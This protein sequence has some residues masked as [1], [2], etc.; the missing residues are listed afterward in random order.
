ME[1]HHAINVPLSVNVQSSPNESSLFMPTVTA[2]V[3]LD[4]DA[5]VYIGKSAAGSPK[6]AAF[7]GVGRSHDAQRSAV[8]PVPFSL[9]G[10][11][12]A[13]VISRG[14]SNAVSA[15]SR[16]H[17][18]SPVSMRHA[19]NRSKLV[20]TSLAVR[21]GDSVVTRATSPGAGG[22]SPEP[23]PGLEPQ[24][25]TPVSPANVGAALTPP[26][27]SFGITSGLDTASFAMGGDGSRS[28][29]DPD[30]P[31]TA[32][33][34]VI[35]QRG[36]SVNR[37]QRAGS[38]H[39]DA[40]STGG[41]SGG[42][43][44]SGGLDTMLGKT[45]AHQRLCN[46][47]SATALR[48]GVVQVAAHTP[49]VGSSHGA[50]ST[51]AAIRT[52]KLP[53]AI[54]EALQVAVVREFV[55]LITANSNHREFAAQLASETHL[56][57]PSR[58]PSS[59]STGLGGRY[60][61][62]STLQE[63]ELGQH[64]GQHS[65]YP[66]DNFAPNG[67]MLSDTLAPVGSAP[68]AAES[69]SPLAN[70]PTL[71]MSGSDNGGVE[72]GARPP[73]GGAA[74]FRSL[75]AWSVS[76]A[77]FVVDQQQTRGNAKH[78]RTESTTSLVAT[79]A[80]VRSTAAAGSTQTPCIVVVQPFVAGG[81]IL[82]RFHSWCRGA[83][84]VD[85]EIVIRS[86]VRC[87]LEQLALIHACGEV[88]GSVKATN[89]FSW[90]D[91]AEAH[92]AASSPQQDEQNG[93]T[94]ATTRAPSTVGIKA[95]ARRRS[96]RL[97]YAAGTTGG[98]PL[99]WCT[100]VVLVDGLYHVLDDA[101]RRVLGSATPPH[102][103]HECW[104]AIDDY[105]YVLPPECLQKSTADVE[106]GEEASEDP[107][108][109]RSTAA[110]PRATSTA[111]VAPFSMSEVAPNVLHHR[112][113]QAADLWNIGLMA[114][115]VADGGFPS[116][117]RRQAKPVPSL[118]S[119]SGWSNK[120]ASFVQV[121]VSLHPEQRTSAKGLLHDPWFQSIIVDPAVHG[122]GGGGGLPS[123]SPTHFRQNVAVLPR[124]EGEEELLKASLL[125]HLHFRGA[126]TAATPAGHLGPMATPGGLAGASSKQQFAMAAH[127]HGAAASRPLR[128]LFDVC[129]DGTRVFLPQRNYLQTVA[130]L[131]FCC[132]QQVL[133]TKR[134][135]ESTSSRRLG[136]IGLPSMAQNLGT[137]L[138]PSSISMPSQLL[139]SVVTREDGDF[140]LPSNTEDAG[141]SLLLIDN[142]EDAADP[143][144]SIT[145]LSQQQ[146]C[147]GGLLSGRDRLDATYATQE[148]HSARTVNTSDA[149]EEEGLVGVA[150]P[151]YRPGDKLPTIPP[152]SSKP[153][154]LAAFLATMESCRRDS[155]LDC[156]YIVV[157]SSSTVAPA[158]S[159]T[160]LTIDGRELTVAQRREVDLVDH[161]YAGLVQAFLQLYDASPICGDHWLLSILRLMRKHPSTSDLIEPVVRCWERQPKHAPVAAASSPS[162]AQHHP[163]SQASKKTGTWAAGESEGASP[164][165]PLDGS[166]TDFNNYLFSKWITLG[167]M[168]VQER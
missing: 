160:V 110:T 102:T 63:S 144:D 3:A 35:L 30:S 108:K 129:E 91:V 43:V 25:P 42:P 73:E 151:A 118:S 100:D 157:T 52:F 125:Q 148:M 141:G 22:S 89:L 137:S 90:R 38:R 20:L 56:A 83:S 166:P 121:C 116:W 87:A 161:R 61:L 81:N 122:G 12:A 75:P 150:V 128:H 159:E 114:I 99:E 68:L 109:G 88:H 152:L 164:P 50:V 33:G 140:P 67:S 104:A 40:Y 13:L 80:A 48:I 158:C 60:R 53:S 107:S 92:D 120:F 156:G 46:V 84:R 130:E 106:G 124:N 5:P 74:V 9:D 45:S 96:S 29:A 7:R 155:L 76:A 111:P 143:R 4:M 6:G 23:T 136:T 154:F 147:S 131:E 115:H 16:V 153:P 19:P 127:H 72:P 15:A 51:N 66:S 71:V 135:V 70:Q 86:I 62:S 168:T 163:A 94:A 82:D 17:P 41:A 2:L 55:R 59:Q 69:S 126:S 49:A 132:L 165:L 78:T 117:L 11:D 145:S 44:G 54:P 142:N 57:P 95:P 10:N 31:Q 58:S 28:A 113:T 101:A 79:S 34:R 103:H 162:S 8:G 36:G 32:H 133:S 47:R 24:S 37:H 138:K 93:A 146:H 21:E 97:R 27:V 85:Q 119:T 167:A 98:N 149:G 105:D 123:A 112:F 65:Q 134:S 18:S 77:H 39:V 64:A 1:P 14:E 139:P 26:N